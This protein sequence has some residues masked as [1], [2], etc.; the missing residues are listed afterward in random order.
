M[1]KGNLYICPEEAVVMYLKDNPL[2]SNSFYGVVIEPLDA[3]FSK[4]HFCREWNKKAFKGY[5]KKLILQNE[6]N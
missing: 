6:K 2:N 1:I 3:G 5:N 4:G